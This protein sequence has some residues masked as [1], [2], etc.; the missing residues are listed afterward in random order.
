LESAQRD[1]RLDP[2]ERKAMVSKEKTRKRRKV[3]VSTPSKPSK[4]PTLLTEA[5]VRDV[6]KWLKSKK[7]RNRLN[8]IYD[9]TEKKLEA[10]RELQAVDPQSIRRPVTI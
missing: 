4:K 6:I 2:I 7:G 1:R 8:E 3:K 9:E 10:Y 5:A